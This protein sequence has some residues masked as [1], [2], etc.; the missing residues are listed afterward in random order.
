M[1]TAS[2][3]FLLGI[4]LLHAQPALPAP[5]WL[6]MLPLLVWVAWRRAR[7]RPA[8]IAAAGFLWALGWA[9]THTGALAPEL[10][11]VDL[12]VEGWIA[13]LPDAGPRRVRFRFEVRRMTHEGREVDPGGTLDLAWYDAPPALEVGER[14]ALTVRLKRP[15]GL[16]N[17]GGRDLERWLF[18]EGVAAR[19]YVRAQPPPR[20]LSTAQGHRLDRL[21]QRVAHQVATALP[22]DPHAG[23]LTALAV[24]ARGGIEEAHWEVFTRTGTGHLLAIS[25]LHI[26]LVGGLA[27]LLARWAWGAV[28][29]LALRWPAAKAGASAALMAAFGYALLAG[30]SLPTRRALIMLGVAMLALLWQ[31]TPAPG[32]TLALALLAVLLAQPGAPLGGGF[33]LSFA[34]VAV[35]LYTVAGRHPAPRDGGWLRLQLAITVGLAPATVILFGHLSLLSPLANLVA[36]PWAG[37]TVI[38]LTL[39]GVVAGWIDPGLQTLVLGLAAEAMDWLWRFLDWLARSPVA[40]LAHPAPPWWTLGFALPGLVLL[41]GPRGLPGRWLG[42][43]LCLPLLWPPLPAPAAGEVWLTV[44]DV[45]QGLATVVRTRHHALLYDAGPRLGAGFD[46]GRLAVAP[47]LRS[48]GRRDLDVLILSHPD[49]QHSGG[50]RSVLA[51]FP[52]GRVLTPRPLVVPVSGARPCRD[53]QRWE[54]DGVAFRLLHPPPGTALRGDDAS[55]VLLVEGRGGRVLLAGDLEAAG[56]RRLLAAHGPALGAEV[57]VAP[58]HGSRPLPVPGFLQTVA[59]RI[60]V[61]STGYRNRHGH[62]RAGTTASFQGGGVLM[63]TARHGAVEVRLPPRGEITVSALRH[64]ERRY[65]HAPP[66][67]TPGLISSIIRGW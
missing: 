26:G 29:G 55:C 27:F 31:R 43:P 56:L 34:A 25:G 38:P 35:I 44:L 22:D 17:P 20:R 40:T 21:R 10:E 28:P 9:W 8:A 65:W 61:F 66:G 1:A 49:R 67:T 18:L 37:V 36:I 5:A 13:S 54:W 3:A 52:A 4:V 33:W 12:A 64:R 53:G 24:G 51:R 62:P 59:P 42:V 15:R 63:D 47:F 11:G 46:T 39:V 14:W 57:L 48:T 30:F 41:L 19:G 16:S 50:A 32:R 6:V 58:H 2:V 23:T 60:T 45:G 7:L